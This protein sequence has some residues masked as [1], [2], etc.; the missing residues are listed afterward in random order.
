MKKLLV[1]LLSVLML[2]SLAACGSKKAEEP[3]VDDTPVADENPL[4]LVEP[5]K[6]T[7][8][9]S[10]DYQPM[11]FVDTTKTGQDMFVGSDVELCKYIADVLGLELVIKSQDFDTCQVSVAEKIV[12]LS[13][14]GYSYT[15]DRA[16]AYLLSED[17][18][19]DGDS[20]Q[21]AI[22]KKGNEEL[23]PDL[24]ALNKAGVE[25]AAQNGALQQEIVTE[26]LPNATLKPIDD[27]NT[28]YDQLYAGTYAAVA[29]AK[30]T[31][32]TLIESAPDKFVMVNG[33]FDDSKYTGYHALI[34][35]DNTALLEA[36]NAAIAGLP[37]G[38][39]AEWQDEAIALFLSLGDAASEGIVA[40]E[41]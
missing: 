37:E 39:Y 13:I 25:V 11:E 26:Q 33:Q 19:S 41:E 6:L 2:V 3:V 15:S 12:D 38:Q 17:Y 22:I 5:G 10:T 32:T 27:L 20:G 28:A 7:V 14:S 35:L 30:T 23:Y 40:E 8:S 4:N 21:V 24:D 18:F 1:V 9:M 29:V 36:V 16:A 34:N 31:A